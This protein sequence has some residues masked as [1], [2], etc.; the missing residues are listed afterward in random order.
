MKSVRLSEVPLMDRPREKLIRRGA[1]AL[2]DAELI[3]I[4]LGSGIPGKNVV[5]V[6]RSLL[7]LGKKHLFPKAEFSVLVRQKGI[8]KAKACVLIAAV[9][10]GKRFLQKEDGEAPAMSAPEAIYRFTRDLSSLKKEHFVVLYLNT[11]NRL[12]SRETISIG[13]LFSSQVHPREVFSPAL[14]LSAAG[15]VLVHN[16]PSGDPEPSPSDRV[17]TDRLVEAGK[18]MGIDVLD[19]LIIGNKRYFSF[20]DRGLLK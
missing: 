11:K 14:S 5:S 13:S 9:E 4:L 10:L 1:P 12:I 15:V 16:H 8:G 17:L 2:T 6:A 7:R 20:H 3:A 19:H 18:L